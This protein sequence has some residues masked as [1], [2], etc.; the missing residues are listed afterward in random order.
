MRSRHCKLSH[1]NPMSEILI[2]IY[3]FPFKKTHLKISSAK[4]RP[5][6]LG[7]N[8]LKLDVKTPN[9]KQ[10]WSHRQLLMSLIS[11]FF[12][13]SFAATG[14]VYR[15]RHYEEKKHCI[16]TPTKTNN[17]WDASYITTRKYTNRIL[18]CLLYLKTHVF[19]NIKI[20]LIFPQKKI[21]ET[22]E[23]KRNTGISIRLWFQT[24]IRTHNVWAHYELDKHSFS[25]ILM[26]TLGGDLIEAYH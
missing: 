17:S 12:V 16:V 25:E 13:Q 10:S 3:T 6:C 11:F 7:L 2:E 22:Q 1:W 24:I 18:N 4:W 8:E 9:K 23:Y 14:C 20:T 5:F 19:F 21:R 26:N 15:F